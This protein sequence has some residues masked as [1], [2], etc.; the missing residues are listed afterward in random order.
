MQIM[1]ANLVKVALLFTLLFSSQLTAQKLTVK[2]DATPIDG[3]AIAEFQSDSKGILI[4]RMSSTEREDI[5]DPATG[6]MVFDT[7]TESF[8]F[9]SST[10][11]ESVRDKDYDK[12]FNYDCDTVENYVLG[13][14]NSSNERC[15]NVIHNG[16]AVTGSEEHIFTI[17][18]VEDALFTRVNVNSFDLA[19]GDTLYIEHQEEDGCDASSNGCTN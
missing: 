2:E 9:Y 18:G 5:N 8:W 10:G 7:T 15:G 13:T 4:P 19:V 1:P 16:T 6:L 14:D 3:S 12:F 11:W 17:S